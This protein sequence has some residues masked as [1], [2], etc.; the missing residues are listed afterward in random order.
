MTKLNLKQ[1]Q[2]SGE[3]FK[4]RLDSNRNKDYKFD[5]TS[6]K[7]KAQR[8]KP[9]TLFDKKEEAAEPKPRMQN[10]AATELFSG[11]SKPVK[12]VQ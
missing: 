4:Q 2:S 7:Q 11:G 6:V 3:K 9:G 1:L 5:T 10:I 8:F 12:G